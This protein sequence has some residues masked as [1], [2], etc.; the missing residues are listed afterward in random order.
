MALADSGFTFIALSAALCGCSGADHPAAIVDLMVEAGD[1]PPTSPPDLADAADEAD[2]GSC[3][4]TASESEARLVTPTGT[5]YGTLLMPAG[6]APFPVALII[7]G[8][9][10]TDRNG[11]SPPTLATDAYRELAN[12]LSEHHV[13]SLR[14]DKRGIGESVAA[15]PREVDLRFEN[16]SDDAA[17][18]VTRLKGDKR[19]GAVVV[20]GH[21]EGS[22]LG[23]LAIEKEPAQAFVSLAGVGRPASAVLREQLSK[24]LTGALLAQSNQ[25]IDQL[26]A[27]QEVMDVPTELASLFRPSVQPYLISWFKYDASKEI[28]KLTLPTLIAQGTTDI[29][30]DVADAQLLAA[31]RPDATLLLVDGMCHVLKMATLDAISQN[32][33]YTNRTLPIAKALVAG[34][35]GFLDAAL[36]P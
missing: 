2:G 34:V 8:S 18:W 35:D 4:V 25:I 11:N 17:S 14:Y 21:S 10:P 36:K 23:M 29:Q 16:Y 24:Q 3:A 27:G 15:A 7:A 30:V 13:A 19:F 20:I 6:C 22:L 5:I 1:A 33:A 12:A 28:A 31:A 32:A 9:G 26:E